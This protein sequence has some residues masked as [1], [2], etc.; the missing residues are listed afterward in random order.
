MSVIACSKCGESKDSSLYDRMTAS[1]TGFRPD[2]KHCC[3]V[4]RVAYQKAHPEKGAARQAKWRQENPEAA[5][6]IQR[7]FHARNRD[8]RRAENRRW[9]QMNKAA[10]A[11]RS[12]AQRAVEKRATPS[13]ANKRYI[14]LFYEMAKMEASRTGKPVHVDH[15]VP[16]NSPLVCGLHVEDNLQLLFAS[17]NIAKKN[18][19]V[20]LDGGGLSR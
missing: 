1:K 17:D 3:K 14:N 11:N 16:L 2:C 19:L 6:A 9:Q 13:W 8:K 4:R 18:R 7:A 5:R 12:A 20:E 10:D 15:I